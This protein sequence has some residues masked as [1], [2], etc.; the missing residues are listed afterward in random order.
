M[1]AL[2][3]R[4]FV[5]T[6]AL[7]SAAPALPAWAA[8]L[9]A[10]PVPDPV[11]G[12]DIVRLDYNESP[13]GPSPLA[14]KALEQ[15][16]RQSGRYYYEQQ[17]RLIEL[18]ARQNGIPEDH[19]A[20]FC[21]SRPPLQ[22]ALAQYAGPRSVVAAAPTY[23]S[24]AAGASSV[25][26]AVHEVPLDARHAHDARAM[27]AADR[28]AGVIYLCNPNNPTGTL[29]PRADIEQV[30]THKPAGCL[31]II[32][33]AYIHFSDAP[34]CL[35][36][37]VQHDDVMV[38]RTFSKLYGMAGA[39][40]GLAIARPAVLTALQRFNGRNF[41]SLAASLGGIASLEQADLVSERKRTNQQILHSTTEH[42]RAAGYRCTD[43]Q[44]NCFMVQL[45]RPAQ[46]V[47][48]ALAR[49]KV[50]VGRVFQAWPDWM[51]VTVGTPQQMQAFLAAFEQVM[52][53]A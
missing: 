32:D 10:G 45:G 50:R 43:A 16:G 27:L 14:V 37:A 42:L 34:P 7:A 41:I 1:S 48:E 5:T 9:P 47:I 26:A 19:V 31:A 23:D 2:S 21:G 35:D 4:R 46:P 28:N 3:R 12:D 18:F 51:R 8:Q 53:A 15:G 6:A 30:V 11:F 22:Y 40:L 25:G 49:R 39:R 38:L 44:A 52:T 13:Y 17:V 20:V 36:L 24:V 33:E 29:T